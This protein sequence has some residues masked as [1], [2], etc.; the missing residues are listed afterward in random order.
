[1]EDFVIKYL[2][3]VCDTS[4]ARVT[5]CVLMSSCRILLI[6]DKGYRSETSPSP[7]KWL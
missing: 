4:I 1:M 2:Q 5:G 3:A 7:T 6:K